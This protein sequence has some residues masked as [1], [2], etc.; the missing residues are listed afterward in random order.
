M[1]TVLAII[2]CSIALGHHVTEGNWW[3]TAI[4]FVCITM[5]TL[6]LSTLLP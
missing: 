4:L 6:L 3:W 5:N 2:L 1:I